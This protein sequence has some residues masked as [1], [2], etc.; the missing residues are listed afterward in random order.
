MLSL[1]DSRKGFYEL[2]LIYHTAPK[3][4]TGFTDLHVTKGFWSNLA[5]QQK[6]SCVQ[7]IPFQYPVSYNGNLMSY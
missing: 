2:E 7:N 4:I 1:L 5:N 6:V 3:F